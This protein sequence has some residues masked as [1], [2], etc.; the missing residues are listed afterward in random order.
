MK[1][2]GP[3]SCLVDHVDRAWLPRSDDAH[4]LHLLTRR[5]SATTLLTMPS[6]CTPGR[7]A[8]MLSG[9]VEPGGRG[10][11]DEPIHFPGADAAGTLENATSTLPF[12]EW[13]R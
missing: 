3:T 8:G 9:A 10:G 11:V 7:A 6:D 1:L 4:S 13:A 5:G 12:V 2:E